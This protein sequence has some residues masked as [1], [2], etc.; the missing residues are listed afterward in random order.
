MNEQEQIQ[1][2][3]IIIYDVILVVKI[4]VL[5]MVNLIFQI[6]MLQTL[7]CQFSA[8][9]LAHEVV[10]NLCGKLILMQQQKLHTCFM[11]FVL[12]LAAQEQVE[13]FMMHEL[14]LDFQVFYPMLITM[15]TVQHDL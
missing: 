12:L 1:I 11:V 8:L 10:V 14:F 5:L 3:I 6:G 13:P 15:Q 7:M 4:M 2:Q 9:S